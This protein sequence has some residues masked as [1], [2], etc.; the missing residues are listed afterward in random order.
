MQKREKAIEDGQKSHGKYRKL[1]GVVF[2][3]T[4]WGI[5]LLSYFVHIILL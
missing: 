2:G 1:L 4:Y 3:V 5:V